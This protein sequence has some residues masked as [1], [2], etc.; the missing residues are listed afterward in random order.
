MRSARHEVRTGALYDVTSVDKL[1]LVTL[2]PGNFL[3][4]I[5]APQTPGAAYTVADAAPSVGRSNQ[6]DRGFSQFSPRVK[7]TRLYGSRASAY[8]YVGRF[9]TPFSLE[10][11]SPAAAHLLNLPLQPTIAQFDLK[12]QR[13]WDFE[14]G[15]HLPLGSGELGLRVAQ[16]IATD[17]I[18]DT[19]VGVTALH[20]DINYAR[21]NISTQSVAHQR[22]LRDG[23]RAYFSVAHTRAVNKGCETQLLA[24]CFGAPAD[25]TPAD[26]DQ[27]WSGSGGSLRN[28]AR[29]GWLTV[30]GEM[31]SMAA[32]SPRRTAC[33]SATSA[34]SRHT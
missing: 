5:F 6:F 30:D 7:L 2:Q 23:G 17:L 27:R 21:G 15:G 29:G 32:A 8:A 1:Y 31:G 28:D 14:I 19:Q 20:Q 13:D 34:R 18:D 33:P 24:P 9:F 12:P 16:K 3:A 25:W 10:N 11:V 22:P 26:H 4:P